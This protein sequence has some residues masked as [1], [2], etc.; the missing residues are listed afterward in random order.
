MKI[1]TNNDKKYR[2]EKYNILD[3]KLQVFYDCYFKIRLLKEQYY[4]AYLVMLK[5]YISNFYYNK[6]TGRKY[7]FK[8]IINFIKAH[9]KIKENY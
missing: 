8:T 4:N 3:V 7:D 6:L 1:Y 2:E 9:F 5:K